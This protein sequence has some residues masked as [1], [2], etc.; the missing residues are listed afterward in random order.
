MEPAS[1][2]EL[3]PE[4]LASQAGWV[5]RLARGL[6]K[7]PVLAEDLAQETLLRALEQPPREPRNLR[8][9]LATVLRNLQRQAFRGDQRRHLREQRVSSPDKQM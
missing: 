2:P 4:A 9:W 1:S 3:S 6:A 7:D 5:R 8:A